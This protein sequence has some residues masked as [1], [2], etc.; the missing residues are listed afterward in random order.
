ML[1]ILGQNCAGPLSELQEY[2]L[3]I[4]VLRL[5][6]ETDRQ[7]DRTELSF[8]N[9]VIRLVQSRCK[10][11]FEYEPK[12][13]SLLAC[14][15]TFLHCRYGERVLLRMAFQF[16]QE[17]VVCTKSVTWLPEEGFHPL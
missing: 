17:I 1:L 9:K 16:P 15:W 13:F 6:T 2:L 10:G 11:N 12:R 3:R 5:G 7:I 14:R 8:E 4:I